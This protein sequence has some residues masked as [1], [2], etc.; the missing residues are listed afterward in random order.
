[1][2]IGADRGNSD[3]VRR[4]IFTAAYSYELPF[5]PGKPLANVRRARSANSSA[6]GSWL[7]LLTFAAECRF[8]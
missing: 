8:R 7:V 2:T 1:M 5:G 6:A 3:Q 4:H